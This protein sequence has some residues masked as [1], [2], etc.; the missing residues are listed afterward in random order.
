MCLFLLEKF[1]N[2]KVNLEKSNFLPMRGL[3]I[4]G[5]SGFRAAAGTDWR[6][7]LYIFLK[8]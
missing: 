1:E 7:E 4:K 6:R 5:A 2:R 3:R 8:H